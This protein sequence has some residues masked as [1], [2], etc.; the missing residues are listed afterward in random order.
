[1]ETVERIEDVRAKVESY[2]EVIDG[3]CELLEKENEALRI[4]DIDT[5]TALFERKSKTVV[6]YRSLIAY[7]LK[8]VE[9]V[10]EL[11]ADEALEMKNASIEL[12]NLLKENDVLL[13]T[14]M[15]VSENIMNSIVNI[16]KVTTKSNTTSYGA[17][18][19]YSRMSNIHSAMAFNRTL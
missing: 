19:N 9:L 3:F 7:F 17:E 8:N 11:D 16:A 2:L 18:G 6:T 4:Y 13:K 12:D 15:E 14:K 10:K 5:V 1:M